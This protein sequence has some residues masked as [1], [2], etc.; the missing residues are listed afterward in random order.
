MDYDAER[1][2]EE[3]ASP[4]RRWA[5][6]GFMRGFAGIRAEVLPKG[7]VSLPSA[8]F[9]AAATKG[10]EEVGEEEAA[11]RH[12]YIS[13]VESKLRKVQATSIQDHFVKATLGQVADIAIGILVLSLTIGLIARFGPFHPVTFVFLVLFAMKLGFMQLSARRFL[14][15]ADEAFNQQAEDIRLPWSD[16]TKG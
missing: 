9:H 11:R 15:A 1:D 14:K 13:A 6:I 12:A 16:E 2:A 4:M 10:I 8:A 5:R 7:K 3:L